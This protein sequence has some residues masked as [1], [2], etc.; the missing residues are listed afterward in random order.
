LRDRILGGHVDTY[1]KKLKGTEKETVQFKRWLDCLKTSGSKSIV[2][3]YKK[4]HAEIR[5]NPDHVKRAAKKDPKRDHSK[6][7][8]KKLTNKQRK[9]RVQKKIEIRQKELAKLAKRKG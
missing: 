1:L 6:F 8:N 3:L 2:D 9:D 7:C 4:V 5:K